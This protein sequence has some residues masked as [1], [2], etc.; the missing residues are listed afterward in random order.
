MMGQLDMRS[1]L[2]GVV[3]AIGLLLPAVVAATE[4]GSVM[5]AADLKA[6]PFIDA[7]TIAALSAETPVTIVKR[8]GPW[9]QVDAAGK[10]GWMRMLNVR[11]AGGGT[12]S[13][14]NNLAMAANLFRTG[15]SGTTVTTGVKGLDETDIRGASPDPA[16]L[17]LLA[18]FAAY[19]ADARANA[20]ASGLKENNIEYLK[21]AKV[22]GKKK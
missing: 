18:S 21:T 1:I 10:K 5:R 9:M 17:A 14:G 2:Q 22:K 19:P 4:A 7:A 20:V 12:K 8:Q 3:I 15:S 13:S 11:I 16:Q 6:E